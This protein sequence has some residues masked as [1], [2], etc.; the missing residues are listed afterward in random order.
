MLYPVPEIAAEIRARPQRMVN[1]IPFCPARQG[2]VIFLLPDRLLQFDAEDPDHPHTEVLLTVARTKLEGFSS[3][4]LAR[5]GGLWIAGTRGLLKV[6][7]PVRSLKPDSEWHD[8][9]PDR[10]ST[11]LKLQ[12]LRHL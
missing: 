7:G 9:V 4:T 2:V 8:Y 6:S 12:S 10:K 3:M 11:R 5:D 1:P